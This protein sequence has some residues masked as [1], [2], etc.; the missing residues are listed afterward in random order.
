MR[1]GALAIAAEVGADQYDDALFLFFP[2]LMAVCAGEAKWADLQS[3]V[4]DRHDYYDGFQLQRQAVPKVVGT[5]PDNIEDPVLIE[6]FGMHSHYLDGLKADVHTTELTGFPAAAG[7]YTGRARVMVSAM[8]LFELEEGEIL[9]TEATSPN[10]TP[11]FAI[12]GACVCDGG[13]SLTHAA[14]VSRE[15]GIPCVVGTSVATLRIK[16]GDLIEVD[17]TKGVVTILER[18]PASTDQGS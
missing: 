13:G 6:I 4:T 16:T 10:W 18:A 5:L 14:I 8:E 11:A 3:M 2:E 7:T 1:N 9:V 12:V 15:Y 17:G